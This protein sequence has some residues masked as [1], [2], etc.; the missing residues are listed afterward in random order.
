MKRC[1]LKIS[2]PCLIVVFFKHNIRLEYLC[3]IKKKESR[4]MIFFLEWIKFCSQHHQFFQLNLLNLVLRKYF[5]IEAHYIS[6]NSVDLI[7]HLLT[8]R[9]PVARWWL[10]VDKI[11]QTEISGMQCWC[12]LTSFLYTTRVR[13]QMLYSLIGTRKV[14]MWSLCWLLMKRC[15]FVA[16]YRYVLTFLSSS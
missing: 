14:V 11:W 10:P 7:W 13:W 9:S 4:R 2:K 8:F 12:P 6:Y 1:K 15:R 5:V 16:F 3:V